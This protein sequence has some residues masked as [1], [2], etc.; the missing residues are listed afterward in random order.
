MIDLDT[1][2]RKADPARDLAVPEVDP[3]EIGRL[4][5]RPRRARRR[6]IEGAAAG[7]AVA[8]TV[9]VALIVLLAGHDRAALPTGGNSATPG[10]ARPLTR[11]LAVLRRPQTPADRATESI[12]HPGM[13]QGQ[14]PDLSLVRLAVVTAWG[15]KVVLAPENGHRY[16]TLGIY[17]VSSSASSGSRATANQIQAG[18]AW[19]G[20]GPTSGPSGHW[21]GIR[22]IVVVPDGVAKVAVLLAPEPRSGSASGSGAQAP[23]RAST[24]TVPVHNNIASVQVKQYCCGDFPVMRWYASDGRLIKVTGDPTGSVQRPS[25]PGG[26]AVNLPPGVVTVAQLRQPDG[27]PFSLTLQRILFQH[28]QYLCLAVAEGPSNEQQCHGPLPL[29][30]RPLV[31]VEGFPTV[32][33]PHPA[34]LVWGLALTNVS[35]ALRSGGREYVATRRSI[36]AALRARGNL[37]YVWARSAPDSLVARDAN[38]KAVETYPINSASLPVFAALCKHQTTSG[39]GSTVQQIPANQ[40]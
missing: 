14:N 1:L 31:A 8:V 16:D 22:L 12:F 30:D 10:A 35:V 29:P 34:Q 3:V 40:P 21:R 26:P 11:I 2:I 15:D 18:H 32:C 9:G 19:T 23:M 38:G 7:A 13:F 5:G 4:A 37:F 25:A 33:K 39:Q 6:L 24:V 27:T 17:L 20:V 36:P 28:R